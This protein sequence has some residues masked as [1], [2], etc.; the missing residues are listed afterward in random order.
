[1]NLIKHRKEDKIEQNDTLWSFEISVVFFFYRRVPW[2]I[3]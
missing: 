3:P 2:Q 1:M